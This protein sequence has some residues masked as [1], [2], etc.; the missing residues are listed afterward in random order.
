[1]SLPAAVNTAARAV[2]SS[3]GTAAT[4]PVVLT[5][6]RN[7]LRLSQRYGVVAQQSKQSIQHE[8]D[9]LLPTQAPTASVPSSA[10]G[11]SKA[12]QVSA[13][14]ISTA[15]GPAIAIAF[16]SARDEPTSAS[17]TLSSPSSSTSVSSSADL[18]SLARVLL[19]STASLD[20]TGVMSPSTAVELV[21]SQFRL[22]R[23]ERRPAHVQR[24][25][26]HAFTA[27]RKLKDRHAALTALTHGTSPRAASQ[28]SD[29]SQAAATVVAGHS[30]THSTPNFS[31]KELS[32]SPPLLHSLHTATT[33]ESTHTRI[34]IAASH[35][36]STPLR[37]MSHSPSTP[38][39]L[40]TYTL[41][42]TNTHPTATI[43]LLSRRWLF[44]DSS[45][46]QQQ[47][48]GEGVV[49]RQPVLEAG[50][51]SFQYT[52]GVS[53]AERRGRMEGSFRFRV[54][55]VEKEQKKRR[56]RGGRGK[57]K[58]ESGEDGGVGTAEAAE[59]EV[60]EVREHGEG[61]RVGDE[62]DAPVGPILLD[63]GESEHERV[64]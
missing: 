12:V 59:V 2:A 54:V 37:V 11:A 55:S 41:T 63:A 13:I 30:L 58:E 46:R 39:H 40:F 64:G 29:A 44:T 38:S 51:G 36:R 35:S 50:G 57:V 34:H 32:G 56:S 9:R 24:H 5:L 20:P 42:I 33:T 43:Q 8:I 14:P 26:S 1:M 18:T 28:V 62:F 48:T 21:R 16:S 15:A 10:S 49:G 45:G 4:R 23:D 17:S 27:L 60:D 22:H 25:I 31:V 61:E 47:V 7:L 19:S 52:S 3:A 6:Y 53:L